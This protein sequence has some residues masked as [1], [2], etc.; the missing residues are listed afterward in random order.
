MKFL[1]KLYIGILILLCVLAVGA[2]LIYAL[3]WVMLDR[4]PPKN[5]PDDWG[6]YVWVSEEPKAFITN[7]Y[8]RFL[9]GQME[10]EGEIYNIELRVS[11]GSYYIGAEINSVTMSRETGHYVHSTKY[12]QN[13]FSSTTKYREDCIIC[14]VNKYSD[15]FIGQKIVF[16][17][18]PK[19]EVSP[20]DFGFEIESWDDF[21]TVVDSFDEDEQ[22]APPMRTPCPDTT[23]GPIA[24]PV[25]TP[26]L[27][28][29]SA[30]DLPGL[31]VRQPG[32]IVN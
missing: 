27:A 13:I 18:Y 6:A 14:K 32:R 28:H 4:T 10:I 29:V 20:A 24:T 31:R 22:E 15:Y 19:D 3:M 8:R 21:V 5:Y 26:E 23:P 9:G 1:G 30:D 11:P 2:G 12:P 25:T 17:K 7:G 16:T